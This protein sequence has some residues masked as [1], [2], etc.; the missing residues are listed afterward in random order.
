M[1]EEYKHDFVDDYP[2]IVYAD[3]KIL[4]TGDP[5]T[6]YVPGGGGGS[7]DIG[8]IVR[9]YND[10]SIP[11]I[12]DSLDGMYTAI[13]EVKYLEYGDILLVGNRNNPNRIDY[14]ASGI[15]V[16][17]DHIA[18]VYKFAYGNDWKITEVEKI[19]DGNENYVVVFTIPD[20]SE[21][22]AIKMVTYYD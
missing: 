15:T 14:I 11:Q 20:L 8:D 6:P 2:Y 22:E 12:G 19:A 7:I 16:T 4:Y 13:P 9:F 10:S 21:N 5:D 18:S 17:A 1:A 3:E